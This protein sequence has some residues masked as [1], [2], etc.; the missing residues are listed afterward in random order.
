MDMF[1]QLFQPVA[2]LALL[3][4]LAMVKEPT[5]MKKWMEIWNESLADAAASAQGIQGEELAA[6]LERL[7]SVSGLVFQ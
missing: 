4:I 3:I 1:P 6:A 2:P 5:A 7:A